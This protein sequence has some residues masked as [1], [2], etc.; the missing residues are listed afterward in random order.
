MASTDPF[1]SRATWSSIFSTEVLRW[2]AKSDTANVS[3][4]SRDLPSAS[5]VPIIV[6]RDALKSSAPVSSCAGRALAGNAAS[7]SSVRAS[8][9]ASAS[10]SSPWSSI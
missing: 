8:A 4:S 9:S 5:N 6:S 3:A 7:C 1:T 10:S 2:S